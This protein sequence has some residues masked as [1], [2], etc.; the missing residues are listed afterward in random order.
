LLADA[1]DALNSVIALMCL[2][3]LSQLQTL[4]TLGLIDAAQFLELLRAKADMYER[5]DVPA[6]V[7]AAVLAEQLRA[8]A[9]AIE[10]GE[11]KLTVI[12]GGRQD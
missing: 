10:A 12:D 3:E 11:P 1:S 5:S 8:Y 9:D 2:N 6:P 4:E 7:V